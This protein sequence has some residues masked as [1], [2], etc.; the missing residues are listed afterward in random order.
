MGALPRF[1]MIHDIDVHLDIP[2]EGFRDNTTSSISTPIDKPLQTVLQSFM[3]VTD[4][5]SISLRTVD[6]KLTTSLAHL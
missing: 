4:S 3:P 1:E 2:D 5:F 6:I